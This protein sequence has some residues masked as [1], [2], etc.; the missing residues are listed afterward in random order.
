ML[1]LKRAVN[2]FVLTK[3]KFKKRRMRGGAATGPAAGPAAGLP[4]GPAAAKP[5]F[6]S[7][8]TRTAKTPAAAAAGPVTGKKSFLSRFTRTTKTPEQLIKDKLIKALVSAINED[9]N[10][11]LIGIDKALRNKSDPTS[12]NRLK[13]GRLH[14]PITI[15]NINAA[16]AR[17]A[18]FGADN[19]DLVKELE[20]IETDIQTKLENLKNSKTAI[21]Q[22]GID[23]VFPVMIQEIYTEANIRSLSEVTKILEL[24]DKLGTPDLTV[25]LIDKTSKDARSAYKVFLEKVSS[26]EK[27]QPREAR[28]IFS[29]KPKQTAPVTNPLHEVVIGEKTFKV[30]TDKDCTSKRCVATIQS[31]GARKSKRSKRERSK[32]LKGGRRRR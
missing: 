1:K 26:A 10:N 22:S 32:T 16:K 29:S 11:C 17:I 7:R 6:L 3:K 31:G 12:I 5:S 20:K 2:S 13:K 15:E 27:L 14:I 25:A 9:Y 24:F 28:S 23:D 30:V 4:T 21:S 18:T 8:F 19:R